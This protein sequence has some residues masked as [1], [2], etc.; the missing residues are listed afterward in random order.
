MYEK[1]I[2]HNFPFTSVPW[3]KDFTETRSQCQV[4]TVDTCT[5]MNIYEKHVFMICGSYYII[6][7]LG[8]RKGKGGKIKV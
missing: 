6:E 2:S 5:A 1:V 7:A 3:L 4:Y 8:G